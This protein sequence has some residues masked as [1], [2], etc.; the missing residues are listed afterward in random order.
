MSNYPAIRISVSKLARMSDAQIRAM[1]AAAM[2]LPAPAKPIKPASRH[3]EIEDLPNAA[4]AALVSISYHP[5]C[6]AVSEK[7]KQSTVRFGRTEFTLLRELGLAERKE[8]SI[9][10]RLTD[11]G[12]GYAVL[13]GQRIAKEIG[14]HV[15]WTESISYKYEIT[16]CTCGV[17]FRLYSGKLS[18]ARAVNE[19]IQ[20]HLAEAAGAAPRSGADSPAMA[21]ALAAIAK[22]GRSG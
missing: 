9:Y 21:R 7:L 10:H 3:I 12:R 14:L 8:D 5:I 11:D 20:R 17:S 6:R 15:T 19:R 13:V 1:D 2:G 18:S 16:H 4:Q 22:I